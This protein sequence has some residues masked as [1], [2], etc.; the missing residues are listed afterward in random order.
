LRPRPQRTASYWQASPVDDHP[1]DEHEYV[2]KSEPQ[3]DWSHKA[4]TGTLPG[5]V[6]LQ[7]QVQAWPMYDH[8]PALHEYAKKSEPQANWPQATVIGTS[9][10]PLPVHWHEPPSKPAPASGPGGTPAS[11]PGG[12][13]ASREPPQ[14]WSVDDQPA[15]LHAYVVKSEPHAD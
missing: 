10:G 9:P 5:P 8:P 12:T 13:P 15:A 1:A 3:A 7:V 6:P 2:V 11:G 4:V 14:A